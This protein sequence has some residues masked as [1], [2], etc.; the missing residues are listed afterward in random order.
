MRLLT[1]CAFAAAMLFPL[2]AAQQPTPT[3]APNEPPKELSDKEKEDLDAGIP[4]SNDLVRKTCSPCH[5]PD[6]KQRLSRI[7]WRRTT[8]EGWE[9]TIKR[10]VSLNGVK[11][12]PA[13]AREILKYLADNLGLAPEEARPA[14]F[15]VE[16]QMIDYK[17][18]DKDTESTCSKCHSMG[19]VISQRRTKSEWEL[20]VAMHRGYYPL[21][22]FQAFRRLGPV[23]TEPGPDGHPPDNRHPMDKAIPYLADKYPLKTPEWSEWAPNMRAPK[24]VGRWAFYGYQT[25]KGSLYGVTTI[26][27]TDKDDEFTTETRYVRAKTG[28]VVTR[29]GKAVVYT[30][31]QWRGRSFNGSDDK[32]GMREVMFVERNQREL[33]GRWFTGAYEETGIEVTLRRIGNDPIVLG[34][35][36]IAL[37]TG[38]TREVQIH[39]TNFPTDLSPSAIDF[40]PGVTVKRVL[41]ATPDLAKVEVEVA[42]TAGIGPRDIG[43]AGMY[44]EGAAV[45]FD[46]IDAI[47]VRPQAGMARVGGIRFP[48][49]FAQFEAVAYSN[50]ADGKPDTKDDLDLG[51]IDVAWSIEEYT[52]TFDDDDKQYVGTIDDKGLFTPNVDG[53]NLKRKNH[54]DNYGDVWVIATY[55]LP[56][57]RT[58]RARGHLL[59]TVPLYI[60]FDQPE[61]A[62]TP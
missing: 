47:K 36:N 27:A 25:G 2:L 24:L 54:A 42:K 6:D 30:G 50:G 26:K 13:D 59:V 34:L 29:Q 3:P 53:P 40:G 28:D 7:S 15:E 33:S 62:P 35:D 60:L 37:Q 46:K 58:L 8:P 55:K 61:V 57:G 43:V 18:P 45:V 49:E 21:S 23:Q 48:K 4:I 1:R 20:L 22:D 41:S 52:A 32:A 31:F 5:K 11:M 9:Q 56:D 38:S 39:G 51:P 12:E 10:M 19:R 44:R 16:K 14:A 17:F